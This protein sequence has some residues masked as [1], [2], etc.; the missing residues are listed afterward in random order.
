MR[1]K[2]EGKYSGWPKTG[3]GAFRFDEGFIFTSISY[4]ALLIIVRSQS[5]FSLKVPDKYK[6]ASSNSLNFD[7]APKTVQKTHFDVLK[8]VK[9]ICDS[10][11]FVFLL[12]SW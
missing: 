3:T 6:K 1:R 7:A 5:Q 9:F 10:L 8:E 2:E 11:S 4:I 12:L